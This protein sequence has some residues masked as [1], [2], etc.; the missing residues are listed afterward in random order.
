MLKEQS[1]WALVQA[2]FVQDKIS[3]Q[4]VSGGDPLLHAIPD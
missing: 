3:R 1:L 4:T 2:S